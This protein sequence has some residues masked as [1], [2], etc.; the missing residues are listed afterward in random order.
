MSIAPRTGAR[1]TGSEGGRQPWILTNDFFLEKSPRCSCSGGQVVWEPGL[2]RH[3]HALPVWTLHRRSGHSGSWRKG[4]LGGLM[5]GKHLNDFLLV[6]SKG[7]LW[8]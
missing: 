7:G 2:C 5:E 3:Q 6:V 4:T 8:P 1:R